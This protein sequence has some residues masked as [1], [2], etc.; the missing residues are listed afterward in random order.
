MSEMTKTYLTLPTYDQ[1][2]SENLTKWPKIT[3]KCK[4]NAKK[5]QKWQKISQKRHKNG[6]KMLNFAP[7]GT[8]LSLLH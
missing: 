8:P 6:P 4:N 1:K 5:R 3:S 7:P 2:V